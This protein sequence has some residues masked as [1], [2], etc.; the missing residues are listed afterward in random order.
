[1][2]GRVKYAHIRPVVEKLLE[3]LAGWKGRMLSFQGRI[4]LLKH[5]IASYAIHTMAVYRWPRRIISQCETAIK[6]F[7]WTGDA[8]VRKSLV[9]S[10]DRICS[11]YE[12]GGL[13]LRRMAVVNR[14]MLMKLWWNIRHSN[15]T[16][17]Q[18]LR[19]KYLKVN[20]DLIDYKLKS[21]IFPGI[22]WV[23]SEVEKNTKCVIGDGR[24]TSMFFDN[25]CASSRK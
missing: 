24:N 3:Q 14:A 21:S 4:I 11:P 8:E 18:F 16:W 15:K 23:Y 5:V 13:G 6:N 2:P 25:W 12:E 17:A 20:G 10:F 7:L 19:A 1:M 22:R 9:V